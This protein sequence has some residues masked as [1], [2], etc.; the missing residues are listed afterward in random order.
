MTYSLLECLRGSWPP[1]HKKTFFLFSHACSSSSQPQCAQGEFQPR[2]LN[3]GKYNHLS[4]EN[5]L[6]QEQHDP[7]QTAVPHRLHI[8]VLSFFS[9]LC[10]YFPLLVFFFLKLGREVKILEPNQQNNLKLGRGRSREL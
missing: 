5:R 9:N 2:T 10:R 4:L 1:L 8:K 7:L 6:I 3:Q